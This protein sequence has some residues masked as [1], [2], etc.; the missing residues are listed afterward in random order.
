MLVFK[1]VTFE[2]LLVGATIVI[3]ITLRHLCRK[4]NFPPIIGFIF[5]GFILN[6]TGTFLNILSEEIL[7]VY[8]FLAQLGIIVLL[9]R[10]GLESNL[11][12]LIRQLR[13]AS[14]IWAGNIVFSGIAGFVAA[15]YMMNVDI[16]P[17][18]FIGTA[19]TATSVGISISAW[20]EAHAIKSPKGELLIDIAE[21]DD[22]SAVVLMTILFSI[23]PLLKGGY[24]A[25]LF[26]VLGKTAVLLCAKAV[27]FG[28]F[29]I[30]F[31]RYAEKPM[32]KFFS[33][34][35]PAPDPMLMV[36]G[37]G[38]IIA[39]IAELLGFS[40]AVGALFAGLLFSR[41]P[42]SV[43]IDASFNSLYEFFAPFFFIGIGLMIDPNSL[44]GAAMPG[45]VLLLVAII[46]KLV[47]NGLP[48]LYTTGW[49]GAVLISVSMVPRAEIA[50]LIMQQG[51]KMGDWAV[52]AQIFS[53]IVMVSIVTCLLAPLI[54]QYLLRLWPQEAAS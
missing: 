6:L 35:K 27:I 30:V 3:A 24:Q 26:P 47:G 43:K 7:E 25:S 52:P 28:I 16:I 2:V 49:T 1:E 51:R 45:F 42:K 23:A 9:F 40:V 14:I 53:A 48:A 32:M 36:A 21:M 8:E 22:I 41:D 5:L 54:L 11:K 18:I 33:R 46:G 50:M 12:G 19:M 38:F 31:S 15:Y 10:V 4:I 37:V 39:A 44:T 13:P 20:R 17:S 29:C 34:M